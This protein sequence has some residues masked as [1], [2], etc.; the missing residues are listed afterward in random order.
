ML[1]WLAAILFQSRCQGTYGPVAGRPS[2]FCQRY[3]RHRGLCRWAGVQHNH[4]EDKP[5]Y[6]RIGWM[7]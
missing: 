7:Q 1:G 5:N 4:Y 2:F 6:V 3:D